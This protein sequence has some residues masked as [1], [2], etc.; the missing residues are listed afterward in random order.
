MK[1]E[2]IENHTISSECY[3]LNCIPFRSYGEQF[4]IIDA[5]T[6]SVAVELDEKSC[7]L[8]QQLEHTGQC[9]VRELQKYTC[10]IKPWELD[11]LIQQ[12]VVEDYG[13]GIWCLTNQDY[14]DRET[15]I[16]FEGEDYFI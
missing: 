16:K 13:S 14:Y 5:L 1:E 2:H 3:D 12:H 8:I 15:G 4:K 9:N 7:E 6:A 10:S 11:E